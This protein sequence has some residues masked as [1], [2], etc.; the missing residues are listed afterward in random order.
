MVGAW[1][2]AEAEEDEDLLDLDLAMRL[3]EGVAGGREEAKEGSTLAAREEEAR[4]VT[5][6]AVFCLALVFMDW[7]F[8]WRS[9][10]GVGWWWRDYIVSLF[11]VCCCY[12]CWSRY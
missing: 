4:V 7:R 5:I 2:N 3:A 1:L 11:V 8:V 6:L 12:C 9:R 10:V